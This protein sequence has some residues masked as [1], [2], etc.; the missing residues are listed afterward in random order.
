MERFRQLGCNKLV[1]E[2]GESNL[3]PLQLK[4][5]KRE[6][7]FSQKSRAKLWFGTSRGPVRSG[8][9]RAKYFYPVSSLVP[10]FDSKLRGTPMRFY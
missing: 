9:C 2:C 6:G 7:E 4:A 5:K 1:C 8:D 10:H 3:R